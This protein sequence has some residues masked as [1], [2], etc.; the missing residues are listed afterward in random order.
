[1]EY[2]TGGFT[3][4]AVSL[5]F[6]RNASMY[7]CKILSP[8]RG[9]LVF[10]GKHLVLDPKDTT[11]I[12][13]DFKGYYPYRMDSTWVSAQ[14]F[15]GRG[16]RYGFSICE[17]QTRETYKNNENAFWIDGELTPLPPVR[18]TQISGVSSEWIIQDMEGM[19]DL[20]FSPQEQ[21]ANSLG[22]LFS[23]LE[24]NTPIGYFNGTLISAR[25]EPIQIHNLWGLG[26]KL[27]LRV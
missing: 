14:G 7:A 5:P 25:S 2:M 16:R 12:F 22:L 21:V 17:N 23:K 3:P 27:Y 6:E 4:V 19:V 15:D 10:G 13:C 8:I 20:V 1:M 9:D 26:E 18:I 24:Y 11:G